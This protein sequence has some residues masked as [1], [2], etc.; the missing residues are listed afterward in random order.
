MNYLSESYLAYK[1]V[2]LRKNGTLGPLFINRKQIFPIN[3]WMPAEDHFTKG[4]SHR[5]GWHVTRNPYAPHLS[6]KGRV[7]VKVEVKD[8]EEIVRP[9][10]QGGI[11]WLA[12][13]MKV[14]SIENDDVIEEYQRK[15][16]NRIKSMQKFVNDMKENK[17]III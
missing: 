14:L 10:N 1:L 5:P 2:R 6:K 3:I 13:W 11:W 15:Y 8:F 4:Y 17:G 16:L 12:K 9:E 7:W